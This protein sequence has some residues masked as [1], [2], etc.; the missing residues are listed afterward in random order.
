MPS[1][2][3]HENKV[4][5]ITGAARGIGRNIAYHFALCGAQ[6]LILDIDRDAGCLTE[7]TFKAEGLNVDYKYCDVS[8]IQ[9]LNELIPDIYYSYGGIHVLV[10]NVRG[11]RKLAFD[12]ETPENWDETFSIMLKGAFFLSREVMKLMEKSQEGA[13]I[14]IA[15]IVSRFAIKGCPAYQIAKAG[16]VQMTRYLALIGGEKGIRVNS[17]SPGFIVQDEYRERFYS[18]EN[19]EYRECALESLVLQ[20]I[21][22]AEDI[23]E[24]VMFLASD[25]ASFITGENL[26]VDGGATFRE[27]FD[28]LNTIK[29][30][31]KVMS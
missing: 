9:C 31:Q 21:G 19:R 10:N 11:G 13:I 24:A 1:S 3:S 20:R 7:A 25:A 8:N 5:V 23:A 17:I 26:G 4:V 22:K 14:N 16:L 15:S 18:E 2:H 30:Q 6:V 28:L 29:T 12:K 27:S